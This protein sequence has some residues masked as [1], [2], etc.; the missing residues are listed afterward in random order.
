MLVEEE[1]GEC[2][3]PSRI[4]V[5]ASPQRGSRERPDWYV[6]LDVALTMRRTGRGVGWHGKIGGP[7]AR[8]PREGSAWS[9]G[10]GDGVKFSRVGKLRR[11]K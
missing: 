6:A 10:R 4:E 9:E 8:H 7:R 11:P 3:R 2:G 5:G 1:C